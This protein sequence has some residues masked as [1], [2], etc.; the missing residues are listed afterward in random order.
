MT[1]FHLNASSGIPVYLQLIEQVRHAIETGSLQ[2]GDQ[3][4]TI[5]G[6]A[7]ELVINPNTVVRAYRE[8]EHDGVVE[9]RHGSGV[10]I[11][12]SIAAKSKQMRQAQAIMAQALERIDKIG[13]TARELRRLFESELLEL[14]TETL[15][16]E[17]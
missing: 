1:L 7:Q 3:L 9:L 4:P 17:K 6:L 15:A 2:T 11:S 5:R 13:I 16:E 8:L 14:R 10:F 12:A